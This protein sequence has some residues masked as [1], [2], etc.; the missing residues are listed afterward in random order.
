M[1]LGENREG[2]EEIGQHK[3]S[4]LH[5]LSSPLPL[6]IHRE[7]QELYILVTF[8]FTIEGFDGR[9]LGDTG[10]APRGPDVYKYDI[11][12]HLGE[13]LW[14]VV[15]RGHYDPDLV[16]VMECA[17]YSYIGMLCFYTAAP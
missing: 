14:Y 17:I 7:Q 1:D 11:S 2:R 16:I 8:Q 5:E 6:F 12:L 10:R 3:S 4:I 13:G 15:V 9:H